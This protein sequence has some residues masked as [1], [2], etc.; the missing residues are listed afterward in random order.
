MLNLIIVSYRDDHEA[1]LARAAALERELAQA[2][3]ERDRARDELARLR[4]QRFP[5]PFPLAGYPRQRRANC[6]SVAL[7]LG[8]A[9]AIVGA[10]V[11]A[12]AVVHQPARPPRID[13]VPLTEITVEPPRIDPT[14]RVAALE[15]CV[16][17]TTATDRAAPCLPELALWARD[18]NISPL[19]RSALLEWAVLEEQLP[20][21]D[22]SARDTAL[23][24]RA[25]VIANV[26]NLFR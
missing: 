14:S 1:A 22:G 25:A 2:T 10:A 23:A 17:D 18:A 3:A 6:V 9:S 11:L 21:L 20:A 26:Q 8:V 15:R 24:R 16:Y 4:E 13:M 12:A 7:R 5:L 19:L